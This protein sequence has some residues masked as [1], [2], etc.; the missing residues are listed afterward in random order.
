MSKEMHKKEKGFIIVNTLIFAF[1]AIMVTTAFVSWTAILL[2]SIRHL[3]YREQAFQIA[4]AG[5]DYY[6]W[7]LAHASGD[8]QDGTGQPGPYYHDFYNKDGILLGQ[9]KLDIVAPT[10]GSTLVTIKSTGIITTPIPV[11]RTIEA[12][13]AI[14]SFAKYSVV[15]NAAMRF[16]AG[17][18]VFG[19]LHSNGGIRFDGLAHN[20]VT[21]AATTYNDADFD[22]CTVNSWG[23]HTCDTPADPQPQT[24][25]PSRTDV[26]EAGRQYSVPT[27]DFVGLS[28][29]LS[30]MK[31]NAIANGR[32]FDA[33]GV[34]GYHIVLKTD[35][36]FDL[37]RV[38][39]LVPAPSNCSSSQAN[40]GTWSIAVGGEQLLGTYANPAN[41]I[42]FVEDHLWINGQINTARLTIAAGRFP[43]SSSTW[44]DITINNDL[45][46]TNYDG[47]DVLGLMTQRNINIGM[48]SENDLRI[49]A[50]V[51]A[52]NGR[53]GRFYYRGPSGQRCSPYHSRSIITLYGMIGTSQR[54]GF[55][56]TDGTGYITRNIIYD[57]NLL[58]APPPYFP[59]TSDQYSTVFWR[60]L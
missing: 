50:A 16:G 43:D 13:L 49:D 39:S 55:A 56:Y 46:Y 45:L 54:Y 28:T 51:I 30:D 29:D 3:Q 31:A 7:H 40:W 10:T 36:T 22:A 17:T 60:E 32:Y 8:F 14:P 48:V 18:E 33:S 20:V 19:L 59:L 4:E 26:F 24:P 47:Q 9:F 2:N 12:R 53:V 15:A 21:S 6:R 11:S 23:V 35:D 5:I 42:I 44:R 52:Q 37:Y 1:I 27:V 34:L 38:N 57:G 58:Y 41:G 25:P